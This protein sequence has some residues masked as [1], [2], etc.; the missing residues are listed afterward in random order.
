[1]YAMTPHDSRTSGDSVPN[2]ALAG[3]IAHVEL[4]TLSPE[5]VQRLLVPLQGNVTCL[6]HVLGKFG[7]ILFNQRA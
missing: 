5:L 7:P 6:T 1:M 4:S 2:S 3:G